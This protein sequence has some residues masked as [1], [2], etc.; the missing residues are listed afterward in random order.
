[1]SKIYAPPQP[2]SPQEARH[3]LPLGAFSWYLL[4]G[5]SFCVLATLAFGWLA[6]GIFADHFVAIDDA[7][8]TWLHS[9]WGPANDQIMLAFTTLGDPIVVVT[10][11]VLA[12]FGLWWIGRWIDAAGM[13]LATAGAGLLNEALKLTF[14]RVRPSLFPGP[15]H[16]T[17]YSFPSG[18]AMGSLACYG[19]LAFVLIRL[20]R[21]QWMKR[22]VGLAAAL[23]ILGVGLSRV[24][25]G[26]HYPTDVLGG[27]IAGAVWLAITIGVVH[28]VEWRAQRQAQHRAAS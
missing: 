13:V 3:T 9:R 7:I 28:A 1:M 18:H 19:I 11:I 2:S 20:V 27:Y 16:L 5:G 21:D 24:Y 6:K 23:L 8:I 26:V 4:L 25:F 10:F 14:Q 22:L 12:A 17:S 15:F